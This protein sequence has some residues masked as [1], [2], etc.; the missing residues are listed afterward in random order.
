MEVTS[1]SSQPGASTRREVE[2]KTRVAKTNHLSQT[3][4]CNDVSSVN[5]SVEET[6]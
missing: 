5:E 2:Q 1:E 4:R 3:S 6:S